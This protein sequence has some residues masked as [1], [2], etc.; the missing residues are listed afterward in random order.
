M[1]EN[2]LLMNESGKMAVLI[3]ELMLEKETC[4]MYIKELV[5]MP[6]IIRLD[7]KKT[8]FDKS[9]IRVLSPYLKKT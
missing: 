6:G 1:L 5:S 4:A 7:E 2:M 3:L 8:D 9:I